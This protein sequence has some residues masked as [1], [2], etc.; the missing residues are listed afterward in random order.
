MKRSLKETFSITCKLTANAIIHHRLHLH[1]HHCVRYGLIDCRLV[2]Y[3]PVRYGLDHLNC[4]AVRCGF[5]VPCRNQSQ[6]CFADR[7]DQNDQIVH[8]GWKIHPGRCDRSDHLDFCLSCFRPG[9]AVRRCP[10]YYQE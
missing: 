9:L 7:S 6:K 2:N 5:L 8:P 1:L 3:R 10:G 4:L